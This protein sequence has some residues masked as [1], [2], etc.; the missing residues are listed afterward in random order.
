MKT[1]A[2]LSHKLAQQWYAA[3][4]REQ[5]LLGRNLWPLKLTIGRPQGKVLKYD[6]AQV[7][8]HL[9]LWR[10]EPLGQVI[11][12]PVSYQS[13]SHSID[14][15]CYWLIQNPSEWVAACR[16][17]QISK[18]YSKLSKIV[19]QV[20]PL[21]HSLLVRQRSIWHRNQT[22]EIILCCQVAMILKPGFAKGLPLRALK[23]ANID[24]K[25]IE[26][27]RAL[28]VKLLNIRFND[29][30]K[31]MTLEQFLDVAD[32][33]DQWLLIIPLSKNLLAYEQLR[34]RAFELKRLKLPGK[35]LLVIENEQCRYQLPVL[36]NT[37]AILGAGLNLS[38]M[39]NPDF[40][41]KH[42]AYWGDIDTW[43][44]KMLAMARQ[45]QPKLTPVLMNSD[46]FRKYQ[47]FA[48]AEPKQAGDQA[49]QPLTDNEIQL[50]QSLL[51]SPKGRLEQEFIPA[52]EIKAILLEWHAHLCVCHDIPKGL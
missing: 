43:G 51:Q 19:T 5:K 11:W 23:V 42:I 35:Y 4:H 10:Q 48:V 37:L 27:H 18:E 15:P 12:E 50:Y 30:L 44:L 7:R 6:S 2:E 45:T 38:W 26:Q 28:L 40:K 39:N 22:S 29:L 34:L 31:T 8:E 14:I 41:H 36:D 49:P 52:D 25:F 20:E 24:S 3:D 47:K 32:D 17:Q 9:Q 21:F 46:I 13:A 16:D 1:P 33:R